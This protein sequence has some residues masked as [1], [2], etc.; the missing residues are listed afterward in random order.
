M[1]YL[2]YF[3]Y[4]LFLFFK[5]ENYFSPT[6]FAALPCS[7][8]FTL[9]TSYIWFSLQVFLFSRVFKYSLHVA[10]AVFCVLFY[11]RYRGEEDQLHTRF[12]KS[13]WNNRIKQWMI[14]VFLFFGYLLGTVLGAMAPHI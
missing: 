9:L 7:L 10:G 3:F 1:K 5:K 13:V 2:D 12:A 14:G 4:R 6:F 8:L 11:L